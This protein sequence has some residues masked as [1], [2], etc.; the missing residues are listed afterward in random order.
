MELITP[1]EFST[2]DEICSAIVDR[3]STLLENA[4]MQSWKAGQV[5]FYAGHNPLGIYLLESGEIAVEFPSQTQEKPNLISEKH[6][7]LGLD[8]VL[9]NISYPFTARA[10]TSV[11]TWFVSRQQVMKISD[12][13]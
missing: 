2:R 6:C 5:I 1:T 10:V 11:K 8:F 7:I 13:L 9:A 4:E 12:R 3:L